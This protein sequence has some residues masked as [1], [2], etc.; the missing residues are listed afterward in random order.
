MNCAQVVNAG[1]LPA[2]VFTTVNADGRAGSLALTAR[3]VAAP[4]G[5]GLRPPLFQVALSVSRAASRRR[6]RSIAVLLSRNGKRR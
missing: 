2:A 1:D 6:R 4:L 3:R 5:E